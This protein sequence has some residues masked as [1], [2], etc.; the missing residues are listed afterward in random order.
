MRIG[1]L[2][3][4][5]PSYRRNNLYTQA[6]THV[7]THTY[8]HG[9]FLSAHTHA[10]TYEHGELLSAEL[11]IYLT[12]SG[13]PAAMLNISSVVVASLVTACMSSNFFSRDI[14]N[15][16]ECC[17]A[18]L[19][20]VMYTFEFLNNIFLYLCGICQNKN[21]SVRILAGFEPLFNW[22]VLQFC[23][24]LHIVRAYFTLWRSVKLIWLKR[25][26]SLRWN[27]ES[28]LHDIVV[29]LAA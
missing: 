26:Y 25:N 1:N 23:A 19:Y 24:M 2:L 16:F 11:N 28:L 10:H 13:T 14:L 4:Y 7:H 15:R 17:I 12:I 27:L 18:V 3:W 5:F 22:L 6:R 21:K 8:E 20:C 29:Y 9:E